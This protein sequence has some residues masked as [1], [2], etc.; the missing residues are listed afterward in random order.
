MARGA[1][2]GPMASSLQTAQ[3]LPA[4]AD[5]STDVSP[6]QLYCQCAVQMM[7]INVEKDKAGVS[8]TGAQSIHMSRSG[9]CASP[10]GNAT[11]TRSKS[12]AAPRNCIQGVSSLVCR[13]AAL[14]Y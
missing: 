6:S 7:M 2:G 14:C 8:G 13:S 4:E 12:H 3:N 10:S 11:E 1:T 9:E 5:V